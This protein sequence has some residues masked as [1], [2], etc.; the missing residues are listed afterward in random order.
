[1]RKQTPSTEVWGMIESSLYKNR[2]H[3]KDLAKIVGVHPNTVS[4]D[5]AYPEQM[6]I[7]RM[8]M[9]FRALNFPVE[10]VISA[11]SSY[12]CD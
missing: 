6:P 12:T 9:Y 8:W 4:R 5:A 1:M 7:G 11:I 3:K 2:M 10:K